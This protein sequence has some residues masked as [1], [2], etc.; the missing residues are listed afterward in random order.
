MLDQQVLNLIIYNL[1]CHA[2][3][4][5]RLV[6]G[7]KCP[8]ATSD[9]EVGVEISLYILADDGWRLG[10]V[11]R[12]EA[13]IFEF[14]IAARVLLIAFNNDSLVVLQIG[15]SNV[16]PAR[17]GWM[18]SAIELQSLQTT[19]HLHRKRKIRRLDCSC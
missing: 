5:I 15:Q 17:L 10:H 1:F 9:A 16:V 11:L 3:V 19:K 14:K 2:I 4:L 13:Y 12:V 8:V 7:Y 18:K 6:L